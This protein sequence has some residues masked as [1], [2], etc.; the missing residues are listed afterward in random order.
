MNLLL[1]GA[2]HRTAPLALRE[3]LALPKARHRA[4][5]EALGAALRTECVLLS[6]CNR[7]ELYLGSAAVDSAPLDVEA[8]RSE[9]A[10]LLGVT[11]E[12]LAP[13]LAVR[14]QEAAVEHLFRV[15]ASLDSVVVGETQ[16][17]GQVRVAYELAAAA[18]TTGSLLHALF[19]HARKV[20]KRVRKET[21]LNEGKVS[22]SSLA[23]DY[24]RQVF[25]HFESKTILVIGTGKIGTLTLRQLALLRPRRILV[26][27][28]SPESA[29]ALAGSCG[30][31]PLPWDSL[32]EGLCKADIILSTTGAA[33]PIVTF[34]RFSRLLPHRAG[35]AVAILDLAMPRD[36]D[37]AIASLDEVELLVNVDDFRHI[38]ET[39]MKDRLREVPAAEA[40][41]AA[42]TARFAKEWRRRWAGPAIT[43]LTR[44]WDGI[45]QQVEADCLARLNGRLTEEDKAVVAAALRL[46]QNKLMHTPIRALQEEAREGSGGL[47]EAITKLFRSTE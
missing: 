13:A 36:F 44:D 27:N 45:R 29:E 35:R 33:E 21:A 24:L 46:L 37:A 1:L 16:I 32:D 5:L 7:V 20:T 19:Q 42:E 2:N 31:T 41:V 4:A 9:L 12:E 17:A 14:Q 6:T 43:R 3:R 22:V 47:I 25:D 28:R 10:R 34:E 8:A 26:A 30:G 39:V 23:I 11:E 40:I 38:R 15:A 18:G